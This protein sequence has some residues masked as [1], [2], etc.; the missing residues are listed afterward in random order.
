[1]WRSVVT[2][3]NVTLRMWRYGL[4]SMTLLS[5]F[6]EPRLSSTVVTKWLTP[7]GSDVI[8]PKWG[9]YRSKWNYFSNIEKFGSP[10]LF[11]QNEIKTWKK[12]LL[13]EIVVIGF[14]Y[15]LKCTSNQLQFLTPGTRQLIGI[16]LNNKAIPIG[17]RTHLTTPKSIILLF[18][19]IFT[20]K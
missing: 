18:S 3:C 9:L 7:T 16:T 8:G 13:T 14:E 5:R 12:C 11:V 4:C 10:T 17:E 2:R 20:S 1:M 15:L 19:H 6:S